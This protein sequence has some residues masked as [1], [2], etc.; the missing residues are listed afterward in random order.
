MSDTKYEYVREDGMVCSILPH[1]WVEMKSTLREIAL[2]STMVFPG[3]INREKLIGDLSVMGWHTY[4]MLGNGLLISDSRSDVMITISQMEGGQTKIKFNVTLPD[5]A[6]LIEEIAKL[7]KRAGVKR[8]LAVVE[9]E[10]HALDLLLGVVEFMR[11]VTEP[12][13]LIVLMEI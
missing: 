10:D 6:A 1:G 8:L 7:E 13:E 4:R 5:W 11:I 12:Y 9:Q 3:T 2:G